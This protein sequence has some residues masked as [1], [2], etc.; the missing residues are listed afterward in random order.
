M[1]VQ[2]IFTAISG[3]VGGVTGSH[4]RGGQYLRART[5]P[6][7]PSSPRQDVMRAA[8]STLTSRWRDTL[9]DGQ[10]QAWSNYAANTPLLSPLG[11]SRDVG[12]L[13]M[14]VRG[15]AVRLQIGEAV[16]DTAPTSGLP[17]LT[18]PTNVTATAATRV[19]TG[20][21]AADAW[22]GE[23]DSFLVAYLSR[24]L[25]QSINFWKGPYRL[26]QSAEGNATPIVNFNLSWAASWPSSVI[27]AGQKVALK[28]RVVDAQGRLSAPVRQFVTAA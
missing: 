3:S 8:V 4:N 12:G 2:G 28:F 1:L 5:V 24:G 7:D 25:S 17:S 13:P 18:P 14:Y 20:D 10:R 16:I 11:D 21:L 15:N 19:L 26:S 9:T 23:A 6:T 27:V 22:T